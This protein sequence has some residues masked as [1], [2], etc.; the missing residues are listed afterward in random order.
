MESEKTVI[1]IIVEAL[2]FNKERG[3]QYMN[4]TQIAQLCNYLLVENSWTVRKGK[5]ITAYRV[6]NNI[7][8][9]YKYALEAEQ[10]LFAIKRATNGWTKL[11]YR[12]ATKEDGEELRQLI[13]IQNKMAIGNIERGQQVIAEA[14]GQEILEPSYKA[15]SL[16]G[17]NGL[18]ELEQ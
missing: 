18:K 9:A 12:I 4:L 15:P 11:A 2:K 1:G 10:I 14:K 8:N 6:R 7:M 5:E 3:N 16:M 17:G 13:A